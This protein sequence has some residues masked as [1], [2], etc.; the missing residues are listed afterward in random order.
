MCTVTFLPQ[1]DG[2]YL[3][4]MNRDE[5]RQRVEALPPEGDLS[6]RNVIYPREPNGGTWIALNR[7]GITLAL[8]NWYAIPPVHIE[9]PVSRG[10]IIRTAGASAED[11]EL[12]T[13]LATLPLNRMNPFRLLACFPDTRTIIERRWDRIQLSTL[14]HPWSAQV[15]ASS[16]DDEPGAQR[17][18]AEAFR[19]LIPDLAAATITDLRRFHASHLPE[20]GTHSTCMHRHDAVTV[21]YTEVEVVK[22]EGKLNGE[23]IYFSGSPCEANL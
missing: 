4:G 19:Q 21:S 16:G 22:Q 20:R 15:W 7:S 18:R 17:H 8:V 11:A 12:E 3:L 1:L 10:E 6:T 5:S 2:G 13:H 14:E 9:Q 23:L